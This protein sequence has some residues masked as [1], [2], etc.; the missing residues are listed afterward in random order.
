MN[1]TFL[2]IL[3]FLS[4]GMLFYALIPF[5]TSTTTD[6]NKKRSNVGPRSGVDLTRLDKHKLIAYA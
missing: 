6:L 3:C 5:V 2:M 1:L 4:A